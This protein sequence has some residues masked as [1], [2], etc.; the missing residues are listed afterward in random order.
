VRD[1]AGNI[2]G[3]T[4][5]GGASRNC[6]GVGCGAVFK[7]DASG[8]ETVLHSF[9]DGKDGGFPLAGLSKDAAGNLYGVASGGGD[10]SCKPNGCGTVVKI[11]P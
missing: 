7:L 2:Y 11:A 3:T 6:T 5:F 4:I 8:K 1:S 10:A 9:T